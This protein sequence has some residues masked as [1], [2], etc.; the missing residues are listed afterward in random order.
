MTFDELLDKTEAMDAVK[1]CHELLDDLISADSC[2]CVEDLASN[3]NLAADRV[4]ELVKQILRAQKI[5][6]KYGGKINGVE[7]Y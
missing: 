3:I 5:V 4:R 7:S 1:A 2:D 6:A